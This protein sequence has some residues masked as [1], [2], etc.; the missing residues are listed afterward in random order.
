VLTAAA[1][2]AAA[3]ALAAALLLGGWAPADASALSRTGGGWLAARRYLE[4]RGVRVHL[5]DRE[6]AAAPPTGVLVLA[7]PWQRSTAEDV[8]RAVERHLQRGGDIVFAYADAGQAAQSEVAETLDL[9]F[10]ERRP[11]PP[12]G[13]RAFRAYAREEWTLHAPGESGR[14]ARIR[15]LRRSP[16][17]PSGARVLLADADGRPVAF[18]FRRGRGRVA[19]FPA[20]LLANARLS[21]PGNADV[22]ETLRQELGAEWTFD[23][24]HHGLTAAEGGPASPGPRML[25][26]YVAQVV[27]VYALCALAVARR[28]GPAWREPARSSGSPATFLVGLGALHDRLGHHPEAG[29]LLVARALELDPRTAVPEEDVQ[30]AKG[31]VRL[32]RRIGLRQAGKGRT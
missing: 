31:L 17:A 10:E 6:L 5:L 1:A 26:L 13:P 28:L 7:F 30:D 2:L 23:E 29:R 4:E 14:P 24:L 15:A 20:G 32:A 11:R 19:V 22:L 8:D 3:M 18:V 21:E 9:P 25:G 27:F 12:L 16:A